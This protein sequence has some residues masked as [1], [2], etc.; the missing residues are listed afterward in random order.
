M[1]HAYFFEWHKCFIIDH[2]DVEDDPKSGW[3]FITK[4]ADNIGKVKELVQSN[5]RLTMCMM[6]EEL[7]I[8]CKLVYIILLEELHM[9]TVCTK[10]MPMLLSD[11]Q[12]QHCVWVCED[13]LEQIRADSDFL[14]CI[15]TGDKSWVLQCDPETKRQN[16]QWTTPNSL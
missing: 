3:P 2:E 5:H 4:T 7:N 6:A 10:I 13:M 12:K 9:H 16:Q 14:G 8:I 11:D 15:I 1:S